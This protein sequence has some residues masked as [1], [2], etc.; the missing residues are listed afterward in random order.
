MNDDNVKPDASTY[1]SVIKAWI[2]NGGTGYAR[3]VEG[4]VDALEQKN[5]EMNNDTIVKADTTIYN[6]LLDAWAKS[7]EWGSAQRLVHLF[8]LVPRNLNL[9]LGT[10]IN[11]SFLSQKQY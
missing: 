4:I 3:R 10:L 8:V 2:R 6:A 9:P 1:T 11:E 7:G 5:K